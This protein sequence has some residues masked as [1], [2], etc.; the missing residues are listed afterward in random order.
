VAFDKCEVHI[1]ITDEGLVIDVWDDECEDG[2][3]D[4]TYLFDEELFE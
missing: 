1:H 4:T 3:I 2:S